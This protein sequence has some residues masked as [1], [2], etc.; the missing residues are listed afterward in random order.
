MEAKLVVV[1]GKASKGHIALKLPTVIGRS[2]EADLT[3]AHPTIS[4]KHCEIFEDA[5]G[6]R[7][8]DLGS[9]NGTFVGKKQVKDSEL[10]PNDEFSVGPLT[11]RVLY[12]RE[13]KAAAAKPSAPT[14]ASSDSE[15]IPDFMLQDES[16]GEADYA[17]RDDQ[18]TAPKKDSGQP[19]HARTNGTPPSKEAPPSKEDDVLDF[20]L[21]EEPN[22][23]PGGGEKGADDDEL[24]Q[25]FKQLG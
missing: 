11:F 6:L 14:A 4:R 24:D 23:K 20:L 1:R 13:G 7:I 3:V 22:A 12:E 5:G 10:S 21:D 18:P 2:R 15:E 25:F 16:E 9:L 19:A 8:R 17:L